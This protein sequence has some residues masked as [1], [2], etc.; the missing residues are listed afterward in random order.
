[1]AISNPVANLSTYVD[2]IKSE[3]LYQSILES[4]IEQFGITVKTGIK[5]TQKIPKLT[6]TNKYTSGYGCDI[7]ATA[8]IDISQ[9]SV[10]AYQV[11]SR[12][13]ICYSVFQPTFLGESMPAGST[14]EDG[15]ADWRDKYVAALQNVIKT[16]YN[17]FFWLGALSGTFSASNNYNNGFFS[18]ILE[19]SKSSQLIQ[20]GTAS[21]QWTLSTC[22][23]IV[24][25]MILK[26]NPNTLERSD[27]LLVVGTDKY[28]IYSLAWR[29]LNNYHVFPDEGNFVMKIPGTSVTMVGEPAL[30]GFNKAIL[31]PAYN[32]VK[33]TD[34][35]SEEDMLTTYWDPRAKSVITDSVGK[36]GGYAFNA[37][38][39]VIWNK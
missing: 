8:S 34:L 1:M 36:I 27:N 18:D 16:D 37:N 35:E 33:V 28:E 14:H 21:T 24:D 10:T 23:D 31:T 25:D 38:E 20:A 22:I 3:I 19:T 15:G 5:G 29:K 39:I 26:R 17:K 6:F 7:T 32:I 12:N 13:E 2:E 4:K 30:I 9:I 11:A